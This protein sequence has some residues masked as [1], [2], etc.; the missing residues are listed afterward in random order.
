MGTGLHPMEPGVRVAVGVSKS[1]KSHG[2]SRDVFAAVR[3]GMPVVVVDSMHE[4]RAVPPDIAKRFYVVQ[5]ADTQKF[6]ADGSKYIRDIFASDEKIRLVI[7]RPTTKPDTVRAMEIACRWAITT[8]GMTG[9]ACPEAWQVAPSS[10][11]VTPSFATVTR[12]WRHKQVAMWL[13][14]QRMTMMSADVVDLAQEVRCYAMTGRRD[15]VIAGELGG[16]EL[17]T[18]IKQATAK[19]AANEY[20]W[21]VCLGALRVGP[22]KIE[23]SPP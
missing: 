3:G 20:G 14:S 4:Y 12:A 5:E 13:D 1:G 19:Y 21:H 8:K 16:P 9:V 15:L 22:Y 18:A 6:L 10:K 11:K 23:R 17:V 2:I 7:V